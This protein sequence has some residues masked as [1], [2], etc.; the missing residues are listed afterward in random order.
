MLSLVI[1]LAI[2]AAAAGLIIKDYQP[3]TVLLAAGL[4]LLATV[5]VGQTL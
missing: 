3:Q 1:G 2:K 4:I 5:V